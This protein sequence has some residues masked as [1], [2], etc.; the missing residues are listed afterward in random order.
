M[1]NIR[2]LLTNDVRVDIMILQSR[3]QSSGCWMFKVLLE[4]RP[5]TLETRYTAWL[6]A[7][8]R[9]KHICS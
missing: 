6:L 4:S 5:A 3:P 1:K 8:P 2:I 9:N 7:A